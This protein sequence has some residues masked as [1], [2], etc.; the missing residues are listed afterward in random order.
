MS[1]LVRVASVDEIPSGSAKE[2]VTAD[3][4]IAVFNVD[5]E[6]Y[7][8]DGICPHAG[9]PLVN[10]GLEGTVVSCPWHG[11]QFDVALGQFCLNA[12]VKLAKFDVKVDGDDVFV[13]I[14]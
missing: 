7:A 8:I 14:P 3:H 4:V 6:Y 1:E 13:E 5:G 10:G 12:K 2:V 9:A 11:W